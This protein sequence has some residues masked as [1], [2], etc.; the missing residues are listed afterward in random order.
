[1][2]EGQRAACGGASIGK[3]AGA[4]WPKGSFPEVSELWQHEWFYVTDPRS[5]KWAAAPAFRSGPPPQ[6]MSRISR[7]LSWGLA[8]DVP[9]LQSHIQDLFEG[10]FNLVVVMQVMLVR[11]VQPC[12]RQ[13]LRLWEFN[14][15]GSRAI[16][17]FLG[18]THKEMYKSFFGPQ[19]ECLDTTEDVGLSSNPAAE[20]VRNP[21]AE[22]IVFYS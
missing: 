6:L 21:L 1:M 15:E 2:I 22:H 10:D 11:R 17:S 18:L 16:Q 14:P 3:M 13:P 12:K 4:P 7:G 5:A 8:K 9:I 20:Q 19:I